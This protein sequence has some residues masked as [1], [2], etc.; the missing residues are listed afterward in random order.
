MLQTL[1][2]HVNIQFKAWSVVLRVENT[3]HSLGRA[4]FQTQQLT[5]VG[6]MG[7]IIWKVTTF[8][9]QQMSSARELIARGWL[10]TPPCGWCGSL[11]HVI[12]SYAC[13]LSYF[14]VVLCPSSRQI[15]VTS[16]HQEVMLS[17]YTDLTNAQISFSRKPRPPQCSL[18]FP[19][20]PPL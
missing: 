16:L 12:V 5:V 15:L 3:C 19:K 17:Y 4:G 6:K 2:I 7:K 20:S 14:D 13:D 1:T 8:R 9:A 11:F 10:V 18:G